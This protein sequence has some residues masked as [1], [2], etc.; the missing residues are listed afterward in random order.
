MST[1]TITVRR[2]LSVNDAAIFAAFPDEWAAAQARG[3]DGEDFIHVSV[4]ELTNGGQND[5]DHTNLGLVKLVDEEWESEW[6]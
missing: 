4:S 2:V 3:E 6:S 5:E 1:L